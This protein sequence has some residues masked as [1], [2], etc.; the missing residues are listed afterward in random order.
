LIDHDAEVGAAAGDV[1]GPRTRDQGFGG[2]TADVDARTAEKLTLDYGRLASRLG[3]PDGKR[4]SG[5]SGA[6]HDR[7]E[8][9]GHA[10]SVLR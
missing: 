5:L 1:G 4:G 6:D 2:D 3:E 8:S 9:L 10:S 7:V